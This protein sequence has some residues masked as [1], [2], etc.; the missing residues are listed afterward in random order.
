MANRNNPTFDLGDISIRLEVPGFQDVS[1]SNVADPD[2]LDKS[3]DTWFRQRHPRRAECGDR[4]YHKISELLPKDPQ[5]CYHCELF[6]G[7]DQGT[8]YKII[9]Y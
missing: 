3:F 1:E 9:P 5:T 4:G 7:K 8:E 6:F 2:L